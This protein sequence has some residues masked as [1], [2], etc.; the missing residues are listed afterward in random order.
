MILNQD[1]IEEVKTLI[2]K[3]DSNAAVE[4]LVKYTNCDEYD[5]KCVVEDYDIE[6]DFEVLLD[7]Y[8]IEKREDIS[9]VDMAAPKLSGKEIRS[10]IKIFLPVV[11]VI[12]LTLFLIIK[13]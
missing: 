11:I 2:L 8:W 4:L 10:L 5:A 3:N 7:R 1:Q 9:N 13:F 12:I 6:K